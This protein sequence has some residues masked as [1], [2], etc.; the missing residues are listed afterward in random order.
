MHKVYRASMTDYICTWKREP[1]GLLKSN[2]TIFRT[3]CE[4]KIVENR[5]IPDRLDLELELVQPFLCSSK[6]CE[7]V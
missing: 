3:T 4:Q 2:Y 7:A 6:F 1:I 5:D